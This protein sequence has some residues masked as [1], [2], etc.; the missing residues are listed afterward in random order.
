MAVREAGPEISKGAIVNKFLFKGGPS[1][2]TLYIWVEKAMN[3]R[4]LHVTAGH[5]FGE[6]RASV[7]READE[8]A[9]SIVSYEA[10]TALPIPFLER[11]QASLAELDGLMAIAKTSDGKIKNAK[12]VLLT[13]DLIGKTLHRAAAIQDTIADQQ[14]QIEFLRAIVTVIKE[15]EPEVRDRLIAKMKALNQGYL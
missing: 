9:R 11:L 5:R 7:M 10:G 15:E 3:A 13:V 8:E 12:L 1:R 14:G 2:A 6:T 4:A